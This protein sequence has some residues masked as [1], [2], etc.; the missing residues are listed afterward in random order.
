MD[1]RDARKANFSALLASY[2]RDVEFARATGIDPAYVSQIKSGERQVG[3]KIARRIESKLARPHGW[4]DQ[5]H[6]DEAPASYRVANTAP[7]PDIR[8]LVPLISWV[9]AGTW[10]EAMDLYAPGDGEGW[11]ACPNGH[12]PSTFALRVEGDSMTAAHGSS[13]AAGSI[14][15]VDP[16]QAG[17]VNNGDLI[18]ARLCGS[19]EVT[20]KRFV[21]DAGRVFLQPLNPLYPPI[22]DEFEIIGLVIGSF[23][24]FKH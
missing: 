9:Q 1:V 16:E 12:G 2:E 15:F 21:V 23:V 18:V 13:V 20:F 4:M 11:F 6:I 5:P 14:I 19:N 8:G 7:G 24:S 22:Y 3:D 10:S 17:G